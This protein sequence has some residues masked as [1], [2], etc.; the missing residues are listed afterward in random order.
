[1]AHHTQAQNQAFAEAAEAA[2]AVVRTA[3]AEI[4]AMRWDAVA[5]LVHP[6]TLERFREWQIDIARTS[7]HQLDEGTLAR[8]PELPPEV[9]AWFDAQRKKQEEYWEEYGPRLSHTFA[10]IE[11]FEE[12]ESLSATELFARYLQ[13][14]DPREQALR[15]ARREGKEISIAGIEKELMVEQRVVVGSVMED[16]STAQVIY[17]TRTKLKLM[18]EGDEGRAAVVTVRRTPEGWRILAGPS[19]SI[20]FEGPSYGIFGLK[21]E[22]EQEQALRERAGMVVTW[23]VEGGGEGRAFITGYTGDKEPP[24]GLV[25]EVARPDGTGARLEIPASSFGALEELIRWWPL[26]PEEE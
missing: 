13:A 9:A 24:K 14:Q 12:L 20:F 4:E 2:E 17:R 23:P 1:M 11:K 15:Q 8:E 10:G 26:S 25:A 19:E 22:E 16:D 18:P 7:E 5:S 3:F 21:T 6:E